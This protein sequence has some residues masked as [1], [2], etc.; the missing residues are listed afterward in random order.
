MDATSA[1]VEDMKQSLAAYGAEISL[2]K[3]FE[4]Y[5][6]DR[7][8]TLELHRAMLR[9]EIERSERDANLS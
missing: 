6:R 8:Q 7:R 2:L 1:R 5:C 4:S 9:S 3:E